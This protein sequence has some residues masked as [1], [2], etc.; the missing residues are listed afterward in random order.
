MLLVAGSLTMTCVPIVLSSVR[1]RTAIPRFHRLAEQLSF[2]AA[3][4]KPNKSSGG[5][6]FT[7][8]GCH[9][10]DGGSKAISPGSCI[11]GGAPLRGIIAYAYD[12]PREQRDKLISGGPSW[13]DDRFD[14]QGKAEMPASGAQLKMMLQSLL[15]ERFKLVLH[16][17]NRSSSILALVIAKN[18]PKL[19]VASK[20]R[21]CSESDP[22]VACHG[23]FGGPGSGL[24]G[25]SISMNDLANALSY[26]VDRPVIDQTGLNGEFDIKT[27]KW[28]P[29]RP[30]T[31]VLKSDPNSLPTLFAMLQE[32][33]GLRLESS[34][35]PLRFLIIDHIQKPTE[36][37][38]AN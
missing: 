36:N 32:Q 37:D 15:A 14:L 31:D 3:S 6:L 7:L 13:I 38:A 25:R 22:R 10:T 12:V 24:T 21:D 27:T 33:L 30:G 20:G 26:W 18:G 29:D 23:V 1:V 4:V 35:A 11:F 28:M 34:K 19:Q 16:T 9:G 8:N 17:V 2:E 5:T